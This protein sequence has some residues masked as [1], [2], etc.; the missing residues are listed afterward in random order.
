M[1]DNESTAQKIKRRLSKVEKTK[2]ETVSKRIPVSSSMI[3]EVETTDDG[4]LVVVFN[5]GKVYKYNNVPDDIKKDMLNADS[6]G[7]YF[8]E[9]IKNKYE[10]EKIAEIQRRLSNRTN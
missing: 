1:S 7:K 10:H 4:N 5:T 6:V 9:N 8:S 2:Q 3:R